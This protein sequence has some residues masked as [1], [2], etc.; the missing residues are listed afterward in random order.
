MLV[1]RLIKGYRN[2]TPTRTRFPANFLVSNCFDGLV[3]MKMPSVTGEKPK[4]PKEP[5]SDT[6]ALAFCSTAVSA[7]T[8]QRK[9]ANRGEVELLVQPAALANA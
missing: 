9:V 4:V 6:I 7:F 3:R 1:D 8:K 2:N 5:D